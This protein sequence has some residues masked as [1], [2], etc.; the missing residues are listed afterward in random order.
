MKLKKG[1]WCFLCLSFLLVTTCLAEDV[2]PNISFE[3]WQEAAGL[4]Q[5]YKMSCIIERKP[6]SSVL[7]LIKTTPPNNKIKNDVS[8]LFSHYQGSM[9]VIQSGREARFEM[10]EQV[11]RLDIEALSHTTDPFSKP[12]PSSQYIQVHGNGVFYYY[13]PL[14]STGSVRDHWPM[15]PQTPIS[16]IMPPSLDGYK[17]ANID[18]SGTVI[19]FQHKRENIFR[20]YYL[21]SN[22]GMMPTRIEEYQRTDNASLFLLRFFVVDQYTQDQS[23]VYLPIEATMHDFASIKK[24][25]SFE[26]QVEEKYIVKEIEIDPDIPES[27]FH[28]KFPQGTKVHDHIVDMSYT[29]I[30]ENVFSDDMDRSVRTIDKISEKTQSNLQGKILPKEK[31]AS[32]ERFKN[33]KSTCN[34]TSGIKKDQRSLSF[35]FLILIMSLLAVAG[36]AAAIKKFYFKRST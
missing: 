35:V 9:K 33:N 24:D 7:E 1:F 15:R 18:I 10:S 27:T 36:I 23:G 17:I 29:V 30:G 22:K 5:N 26:W 2:K 21:D 28:L 8:N 4:L 14:N 13:S 16:Y 11:R 32:V 19:D 6:S 12:K 25:G 34:G 20:R 3:I 31:L